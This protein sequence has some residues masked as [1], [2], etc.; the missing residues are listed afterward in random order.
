VGAVTAHPFAPAAVRSCAL[1]T[2][3]L[4]RQ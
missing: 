2:G 3:L 1:C 4:I